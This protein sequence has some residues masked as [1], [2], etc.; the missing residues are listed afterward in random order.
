M[1]VSVSELLTLLATRAK[2][3]QDQLQSCL[4]VGHEQLGR[5]LGR[6]LNP[7]PFPP[8]QNEESE[9]VEWALRAQIHRA[10]LDEA[11][12]LIELVTRMV[13]TAASAGREDV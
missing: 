1:R 13:S 10:R 3:H 6:D 11:Q 5:T 4:K 9:S 8:G 12:L 7:F 2:H